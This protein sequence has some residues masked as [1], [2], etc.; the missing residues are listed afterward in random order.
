MGV[1]DP[2]RTS[3]HHFQMWGGEPTA[4]VRPAIR[5]VP[6][7]CPTRRNRRSRNV[8]ERNAR[9]ASSA[10]PSESAN[11]SANQ[12]LTSGNPCIEDLESGQFSRLG[13]EGSPPAH[14]GGSGVRLLHSGT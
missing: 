9:F 13:S 1:N 6:K 3:Y 4:N 11:R 10:K 7:M 12:G 2:S 5:I 14:V 8:T